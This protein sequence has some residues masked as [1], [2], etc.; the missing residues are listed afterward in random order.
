MTYGTRPRSLLH[1]TARTS[2]PHAVSLPGR[3]PASRLPSKA[4]AAIDTRPITKML[5]VLTSKAS[6]PKLS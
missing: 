2:V 5:F 4:P 3:S 6:S 1:E